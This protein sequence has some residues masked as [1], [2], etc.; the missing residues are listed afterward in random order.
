MGG[1]V[2]LWH[3]GGNVDYHQMRVILVSEKISVSFLCLQGVV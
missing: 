2:S 3:A 1:W